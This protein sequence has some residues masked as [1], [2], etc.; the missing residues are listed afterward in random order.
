M[1]NEA[2]SYFGLEP[3]GSRIWELLSKKPGTIKELVA[4][5]REEYEVEEEQ[6]A[7]D[8]QDFI[9]EMLAKKLIQKVED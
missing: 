4:L 6:C 9:K 5:L 2:D 3:V 7:E 8:V 1:S